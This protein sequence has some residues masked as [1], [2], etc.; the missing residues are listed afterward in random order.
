MG[1]CPSR[2]LP[3]P[4]GERFQLGEGARGCRKR[5]S[6]SP[7]APGLRNERERAGRGKGRPRRVER[8]SCGPAGEGGGARR[9]G[10]AT[11]GQVKREGPRERSSAGPGRSSRRGDDEAQSPAPQS[12]PGRDSQADGP[13][14]TARRQGWAA[15]PSGG[16]ARPLPVR[17]LTFSHSWLPSPVGSEESVPDRG[18]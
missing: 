18:A 2:I 16:V 14:K 1:G 10:G 11:R 6:G 17:T 3:R 9:G 7:T 5:Q 8:G 15:G 4:E 12:A 13:Q